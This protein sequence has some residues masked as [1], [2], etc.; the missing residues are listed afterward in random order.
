MRMWVPTSSKS[1]LSPGVYWKYQFIAPVS[2]FQEI[3]LL[4]NRL[5]PGACGRIEL[6]HRVACTPDGLVRLRV[7]GACP[8]ARATAG[9]PGVGVALPGLTAGLTGRRH[10]ELAPGDLA[11]R[12]VHRGE[13]I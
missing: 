10:R 6:G 7:V 3:A 8:P 4:V 9:L 12:R 11:G 13:P 2:G 1:Q 5:S